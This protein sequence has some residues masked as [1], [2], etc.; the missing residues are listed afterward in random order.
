V[1]CWVS[2]I[3]YNIYFRPISYEFVLLDDLDRPALADLA[4]L[5]PAALIETSPANYQAWLILPLAP[6][7]EQHGTIARFLA[8]RLGADLASAK[9]DQIGR[10]PGFQNRKPKHQRPD[11]TFPDCVL[12][13]FEYR[14]S[15][16]NPV[17]FFPPPVLTKFREKLV[18]PPF[19][20]SFGEDRSRADFNLCC[21]LIRKG[22]KDWYISQRLAANSTKAKERGE[23]Y[24]SQTIANARRVTGIY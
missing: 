19:P 5:Q 17:D 10:L 22:Y 2:W 8:A 12:R 24:V 23:R 21:M 13:K 20:E 14:P 6:S 7:R 9:P 1:K 4:T 18:S 11:G 15:T 16:I 3:G